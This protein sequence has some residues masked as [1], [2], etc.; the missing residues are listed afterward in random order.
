MKLTVNYITDYDKYLA[1]DDQSNVYS[2]L[3]P[4]GHA[5][6]LRDPVVLKA[7]ISMMI[8]CAKYELPTGP[9]LDEL[10]TGTVTIDY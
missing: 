10:K 3:L 8:D 1:V 9:I 4:Q 6:R 7:A 2:F 5:E